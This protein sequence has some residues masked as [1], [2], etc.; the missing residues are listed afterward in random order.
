MEEVPRK[1]LIDIQKFLGLPEFICYQCGS[2]NNWQGVDIKKIIFKNMK[3]PHYRPTCPD[4]ETK[5]AF[6]MQSKVERI[7]WKNEMTEITSFDS[8]LLSWMLEKNYYGVSSPKVK[9]AVIAVLEQRLFSPE[10]I[11]DIVMTGTEAKLL[12]KMNDFRSDIKD[13]EKV[14]SEV[15]QLLIDNSATLDYFEVQ[16]N[17]KVIKTRLRRIET[18]RKNLSKLLDEQNET[19]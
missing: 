14:V 2:V 5:G 12:E 6:M 4:C 16:K 10:V 7:H 11:K 18:A 1:H 15:R 9:D 13:H 17:T 3:K 19:A 8:K